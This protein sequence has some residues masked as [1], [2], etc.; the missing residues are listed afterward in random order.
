MYDV[1]MNLPKPV[2][3]IHQYNELKFMFLVTLQNA[4][5][6]GE[7][8]KLKFSDIDGNI[9]NVRAETTKT[10]QPS[11]YIL[12]PETMEVLELLRKERS[13]DNIFTFALTRALEAFYYYVI[14]DGGLSKYIV[15]GKKFTLHDTRRLF[16]QI[17][18]GYYGLNSDLV[19]Y[20]LS[21]SEG[22]RGIKGVYLDYT[23]DQVFEVYQTY[24]KILRGEI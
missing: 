18:V 9:V 16:I 14:R 6:K 15:K 7:V 8:H 5:R 19:D 24:F 2:K 17:L 4:R 1:I 3:S 21:H 13:N 11:K 22:S 12:S 10:K 23:D 20:C